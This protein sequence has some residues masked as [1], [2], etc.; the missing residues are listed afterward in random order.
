MSLSNADIPYECPFGY[1]W[2]Q[3]KE[4]LQ[5]HGNWCQAGPADKIFLRR[6]ARGLH[7]WGIVLPN[8]P[9]VAPD[10]QNIAVVIR[11]NLISQPMEA[12]MLEALEYKPRRWCPDAAIP[13]VS[14]RIV[15]GMIRSQAWWAVRAIESLLVRQ[16]CRH[17]FSLILRQQAR[18]HCD[19]RLLE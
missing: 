7:F 2:A 11:A 17:S 10:V 9:C 13:V 19:R 6:V 12:V 8:S 18:Q 4:V 14:G 5:K 15:A 1:I 3:T 16:V